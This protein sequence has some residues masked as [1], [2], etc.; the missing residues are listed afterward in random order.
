LYKIDVKR[1]SVINKDLLIRFYVLVMR[2]VVDFRVITWN[3]ATSTHLNIPEK[4]KALEASGKNPR[5]WFNVKE[6]D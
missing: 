1:A 5:A 2:S 4:Q 6:F 3:P